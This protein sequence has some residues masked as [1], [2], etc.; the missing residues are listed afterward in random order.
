MG[1]ALRAPCASLDAESA[2]R[3]REMSPV[4][5]MM[6]VVALCCI[7]LRSWLFL[8]EIWGQD[9]VE[10]VF[11]YAPFFPRQPSRKETIDTAGNR[12]RRQLTVK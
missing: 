2:A 1:M 7:F 3:S 10:R 12:D 5:A 9:W 6:C 4:V 8:L 11:L